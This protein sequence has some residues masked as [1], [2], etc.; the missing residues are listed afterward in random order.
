MQVACIP[1]I[2]PSIRQIWKCW[3]E[4]PQIKPAFINPITNHRKE[5]QCV[6]VDGA[7]DEG[8]SHDEVQFYWTERHYSRG[9]VAT[10]VSARSSGSSYLNRVELQNGCMAL[11]RANLFIP[12]TLCGSNTD[13]NSGKLNQDV[14][15]RN[16]TTAMDIYISRVDQCPCGETL[17]HLR[18]GADSSDKQ[19]RRPYLLQYLKGTIREKEVLKQEHKELYEY[20]EKIWTLRK[21][22]MIEGLPSQYLF[23]LVCCGK[24]DCCHPACSGIKE[25]PQWFPGGTICRILTFTSP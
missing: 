19:E 24:P 13:P 10:V 7:S 23:H 12:S 22:H 11:A 4:L 18:K 14:F 2:Q 3:R 20:F 9:S 8:P 16:M 25:L 21:R 5:I 15:T 17:I 6:R 1:R